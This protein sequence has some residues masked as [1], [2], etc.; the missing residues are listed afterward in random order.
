[1]NNKR[2][3]S[4]GFMV[5]RIAVVA[6]AY[7][8][9][10]KIG[11][12]MPYMGSSITLLWPPTGIA[13]A[14]LLAWGLWCWPGV[15][16]GALLVNLTTSGLSIPIALSI[17]VGNTLGP[18]LGALILKRLVRPENLFKRSRDVIAFILIASSTMLLT[19]TAGTL[20]LY[21]GG[22]LSSDLIPQAWLGWWLGDTVGVLIFAPPLL[23]WSAY[24]ISP[25]LH[26]R[27]NPELILVMS[28]CV[29]L[30][31][32]VFGDVLALGQLKLSLAFLV[33]PPLIWAGLRFDTVGASIAALV[34][35]IL[36][37]W[38]TAQGNGPFSRGH[39]QIDQLVLCI[40]VATT[41]LVSY[42]IIGVQAARR[43]AEQHLRDS[44]YRLRLA[45]KAV[46]QGLYDL[47]VQT[48]AAKVSPEYA[49]ML[50]YDPETFEETSQK[51][52]DRLH[53]D[54]REHVSR[55]YEDY[56]AGTRDDYQIEF[57]QLTPQGDWKWI[58]SLG[59]VVEWDGQGRPLR[60]L[61][62]HADISDRKAKEIALQKSE[63]ALHRAQTLVKLGS[64][65]FDLMNNELTW[66]KETFRIFGVENGDPL[67]YDGFL[68]CVVPED[69][70]LVDRAWKATLQGEVYDIEHRINVHG[71]I[72]WLREQ[73]QVTFDAAGNVIEALGTVQDISEHKR[74]E[75]EINQSR[76]L[77]RMVIDATPD[78]IFVK[79]R[80]YRLMLVNQAFANSQGFEPSQMIGKPDTEF[81]PE[82]LCHGDPRQGI[83][84]FHTDDDE[85]F[86]GK[87]THNPADPATL[88]DGQLRW[89]DTL[90][91]PM[92][93]DHGEVMG[94]LAYARDITE[95]LNAESKYRTLVEQIPAVTYI[96]ALEPLAHTIYISPQVEAQLGFGAQ[97]WLDNPELWGKQLHPEDREQVMAELSASLASE[98]P[99]RLEYRIFRQN[100]SIAWILDDAVWLKDASGKPA[101]I[102]GLMFDI[103]DRKHAEEDLSRVMEELRLSEQHQRELR[104]LAEHEQSRMVA[105]LS[106][107][108]IGILFE[109]NERRVEYVNPAF[110]RM[111]LI[112][113][114]DDLLGVATKL[115]LERSTELFVRPAHTSKNAFNM[116]H[117][118]ESS[119]R[120]ELELSDG[121]MLTQLSYPVND[122]EGRTLG[123][124]W[125]YEDITQERH[126]AQQLLYLA[127]RDPLT[128]LYNRHRFQEQLENLIASYLRSRGKFALLYFDLD[129]FKYINDTFGH[130][131]GDTVLVRAAGE[132]SSII[133]QIEI[134][135]RLGGDEFAILSIIQPGEDIN[136]LPARIVTAI[137]SIPLRFRGTNIRLTSS[138]GV[139]VFPEH[140]ETA[141]DLVAHADTAMYQAKNQ[142]KNT[143]AVYDSKRDSSEAM[144]H[145]M[146][147]HNMIAQALEEDLF[148][149][150][151]Q[152][153][154]TTAS[155]TLTHAEVLIRMRDP[156]Q[157]EQLIMPG[158]FIPIAEKNGQI[159]DI[160]RWVVRKT[161]EFLANDV[162]MPP[163]AINI[164]GRSFDEPSLPQYIRKLLM[165]L[166]VERSRLI[167][168]LTET[169]AVSD[170]KDAQRFI[171]AIHQSGCKVC[172]DDFGS[173]FSTFGYLK[174]LGVEILKIDG[175]FIS[176]LPNNR[177]NQIFVK[178]MVEVARGLGKITVAEFVEDEATFNMIRKPG[179]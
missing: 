7:Y 133:R 106:A 86:A 164:S 21:A 82:H 64:W 30:A 178:A 24:K 147:W 41:A 62:T 71:Q 55:I 92:R 20:S 3:S 107:M 112:N 10:G 179:Y 124:L 108:N 28:A 19:A 13:L 73:A 156:N 166:N 59:K 141:E 67:S 53:P 33:F 95:R 134:F 27:F 25:I 165:E 96:A 139:A 43:Y 137:S 174:Y 78:W 125:I 110:L 154:Y 177:D 75:E 132:I 47:N 150:Y 74:A 70:E 105:L 153:V 117:S 121:R 2:L 123:R 143:W 158:Q 39:L 119:E 18:V 129:D 127:E 42:T 103:T 168:E 48:G 1:M 23:V 144:M 101:Y 138:V 155:N 11:L 93:N 161:I 51:W 84:G 6:L 77:L 68:A 104:T 49:L 159:L 115:V 97:D 98:K 172:L 140:G 56:I 45:L 176:D 90:K 76:A 126:T 79:D 57:R 94:V 88:A 171:E 114:H 16:L 85:A 5:L 46:N 52:L 32:L 170:I 65:H 136:A 111:W 58:L 36:A 54:D 118:H 167:I 14:A 44:E 35:S 15:F 130:S 60:M 120:L 61:G 37:V 66:S 83:R 38:G 173:G 80:E 9:G 160:D 162:N 157:P 29:G 69:R 131:A 12:I 113:E 152:G 34:I 81:W 146:T 99:Y 148:S 151:F 89:F 175:S 72:K 22:K 135:A 63:D 163:L 87:I 142:G 4:M 17:A 122:I 109:D 8:T 102:Q 169:A 149:L 145:R 116:P 40:F 91:L 26:P 31:W 128:G 50:G 100:G